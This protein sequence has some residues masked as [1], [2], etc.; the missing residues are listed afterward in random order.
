VGEGYHQRCG[1]PHAEVHALAAAGELARGSD[2]Y[3]TLEPCNHQGR[4]PPCTE[5]ILKAGIRRVFVGFI[6][7]DPNVAGGGSERLRQAGLEVHSVEASRCQA[8]YEAYNIHRKLGRPQVI[9]KAAVTLDGRV[10]T[11]TG[12]SQWI[13]GPEARQLVHRVRHRVDAIL[14][15][16]GTL[17]ADDPQLTTRLPRGKGHDPL[18]VV[19]DTRGRTPATA[20]V[21]QHQSA[22]ETIVA[23]GPAGR[24]AA[25]ALARPGVIPLECQVTDGHVDV[26]DLLRQLAARGIVSLLVEGG[27]DIHGAFL[28]AG[29]VDRVMFFLAPVIV[30]GRE[31]VP[32]V[33]GR[34][35]EVMGD[36]WSLPEAKMRRVGRDFLIEGPLAS[37]ARQG[38]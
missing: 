28:E 30:G 3:V 37:P 12:H 36:A 7:P 11:R 10:A 34:G 23:H 29:V 8:F 38:S 35:V 14:V 31:A 9:M 32:A 5:A 13:T 18:R 25:A 2:L 6:D 26:T 20:K 21:I 1:G 33:G 15:G 22:A 17:L 4:T 16:V 19:M 24:Q 27:G